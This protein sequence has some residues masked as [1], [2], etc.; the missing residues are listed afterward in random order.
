MS[1]LSPQ[2]LWAKLKTTTSVSESIYLD[3]E[4]TYVCLVIIFI[5]SYTVAQ[6]IA[7][8]IPRTLQL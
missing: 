3:F 7:N 1:S 5:I 4:P 2:Q 8:D 6:S